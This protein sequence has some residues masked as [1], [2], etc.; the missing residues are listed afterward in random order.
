MTGALR[1]QRL[2]RHLHRFG[3]RAVDELLAE[4]GVAHGIETDILTRLE[5]YGRL[6]PALVA[7][8]GVDRIV[9]LPLL[10]IGDAA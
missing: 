9:Q 5:Q 6:D 2:V 4:L 7:A 8:L 3:E 1:R 10:L